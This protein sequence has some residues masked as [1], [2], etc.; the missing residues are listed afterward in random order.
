[1]EVKHN[2]TAGKGV[3]KMNRRI[4]TFAALICALAILLAG[5]SPSTTATP[6]GAPA[7]TEAPGAAVAEGPAQTSGLTIATGSLGAEPLFVDWEQDGT[8]MQL[9][10]LR[11]DDGEVRLAYNTC[12]VCMGSPYAYFEYRDGLLICQNCGSGF[13]LEAVG[14]VSGGCNPLPVSGSQ[15]SGDQVTIPEEELAAVA[16]AFKN[17]K[18]FK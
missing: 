11:D 15:A 5:C 12:Q 9:I 17:W 7:A 13:A 18:V 14:R 3:L 16:V 1:M 6:T 2:R 4:A 8:P 10:A